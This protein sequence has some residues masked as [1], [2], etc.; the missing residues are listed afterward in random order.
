MFKHPRRCLNI[1][2][3]LKRIRIKESAKQTT[4]CSRFF[5]ILEESDE[6]DENRQINR[7]DRVRGDQIKGL[8]VRRTVASMKN[9]WFGRVLHSSERVA[10]EVRQVRACEERRA[11]RARARDAGSCA[12]VPSAVAAVQR[13]DVLPMIARSSGA[14]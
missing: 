13:T 12:S 7:V 8:I 11:V 1:V 2:K 10:S 3:I 6:I 4:G 9:E 14:W 5:K